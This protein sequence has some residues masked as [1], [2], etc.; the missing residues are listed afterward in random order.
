MS[1]GDVVIRKADLDDCLAIA[2]LSQLA[3]E[4]IMGYFWTGLQRP[5]ETLEQAGA[6]S[7]ESQDDNFSYRNAWLACIDDRVA[8]MLLAYR[9]PAAADNPER[10]A[11]FPD[12]IAPMVELEQSVPESFFVDM[13]AT[14]PRFRG[15]GIGSRLMACVDEFARAADASLISLL[16]FGHNAG[17]LRFYRRLGFESAERKPIAAS[18]TTPAGEILLLTRPP[19]SA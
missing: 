19:R 17:A 4:G 15:R 18:P 7:A 13:L 9:L 2:E 1:A 14:Y 6:R 12:Y 5:G 11:D 16:V 8:G 3:S 10:P